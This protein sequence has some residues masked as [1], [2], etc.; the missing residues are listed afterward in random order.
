M[1]TLRTVVVTGACLGLG[2]VLSVGCE[3]RHRNGAGAAAPT[4]SVASTAV[5]TATTTAPTATTTAAPTATT[6]APTA[7]TTA[8]P[9]T[10]ATTPPA[11]GIPTWPMPSGMDPN[12]VGDIVK[13]TIGTL[14]GGAI[15]TSPAGD[16]IEAS[17]K[18]TAAKAAPGFTAAGPIGKANLKTGEHAGMVFNFQPG[19][20]YI[21]IGA[22][23]PGVNKVALFLMTTPP[24]P[25]AV[26][27]TEN[28]GTN[29]PVMGA[30]G[31]LCPPAAVS[32]KVDAQLVDG[33]G[34]VGVQI[35][36]K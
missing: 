14:G 31:K 18:A 29:A 24:A 27:M 33:N 8:A 26:L 30:G 6:T 17:I 36:V 21:A 16:P 23:G 1:S 7:T 13:N 15:P 10:T 32:A 12:V 5:P 25:Q 19:K 34:L 22:G 35:W 4:N 11:V 9:T 20:C 2:V 3:P 28:P